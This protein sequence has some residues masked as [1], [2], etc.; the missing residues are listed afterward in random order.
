M[1]Y[2][3]NNKTVTSVIVWFSFVLLLRLMRIFAFSN[4]FFFLEIQQKQM[5][6]DKAAAS[7]KKVLSVLKR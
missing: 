2:D 3:G 6:L 5:E 1:G 4:M 7:L